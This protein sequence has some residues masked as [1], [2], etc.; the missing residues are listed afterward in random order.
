MK[1]KIKLTESN[2]KQV[3]NEIEILKKIGS[4]LKTSTKFITTFGTGVA[5]FY[6]AISR[7]LENS[8]LSLTKEEII[9]LIITSFSVLAH[10]DEAEKLKKKVEEQGLIKTYNEVSKFVREYHKFI[11]L[12]KNKSNSVSITIA[13]LLGYTAL[14][15]PS[16]RIISKIIEEKNLGITDIKDLFA[17][18]L[19]SSTAYGI[20]SL[21]DK[22]KVEEA[23][24][25]DA[26]V[27]LIPVEDNE[28]DTSDVD[29]IPVSQVEE[30]FKYLTPA[31]IYYRLIKFDLI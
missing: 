5:A 18:L 29:T 3:L 17:G 26:S 28:F 23:Y 25:F 7:M 16:M 21:L 30:I 13:D 19:V 12:L 1:I 9:L 8:S 31:I 20:K 6:P 22:N 2:N 11:S 4:E 15:V 24:E 14:L 10:S 27:D